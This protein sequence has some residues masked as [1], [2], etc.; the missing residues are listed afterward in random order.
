M[1]AR[2]L[3]LLLVA[4]GHAAALREDVGKDADV[5]STVNRIPQSPLAKPGMAWRRNRSLATV[6]SSQ[7]HRMN[8][9]MAKASATKLAS[10]KPPSNSMIF[11]P[12]F[13]CATAVK[14]C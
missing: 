6:M 2:Q 9:N 1:L 4:L 13:C 8:M 12:R 11:S 10:V 7:N 5:G 14:A 3:G